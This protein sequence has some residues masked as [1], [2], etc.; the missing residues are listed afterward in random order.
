VQDPRLTHDA[1]TPAVQTQ[2]RT[3]RRVEVREEKNRSSSA[4]LPLDEQ[5]LE[6]VGGGY[7]APNTTW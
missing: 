3:E 4:P 2:R 1:Q 5:D 6:R 7:S